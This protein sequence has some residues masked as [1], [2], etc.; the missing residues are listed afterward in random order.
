[1]GNFSRISIVLLLAIFG[2]VIAC[3]AG[4]QSIAAIPNPAVD[5]PIAATKSEQTAVVAG[6]CFWGTQ[7]VFQH[8]KGV[9]NATSGYSGGDA[10]SASTNW[11][12]P[13]RP[14]MRNR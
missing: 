7:A 11:S 5:A 6:G 12:A 10:K 9:V 2:G 1:M 8:V 3:N 14:A 13:A 4:D